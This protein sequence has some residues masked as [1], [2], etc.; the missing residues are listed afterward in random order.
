MGKLGEMILSI[1][2]RILDKWTKWIT[3]NY[4]CSEDLVRE[5]PPIHILGWNVEK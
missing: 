5:T 3:F 1:I 2:I 4:L